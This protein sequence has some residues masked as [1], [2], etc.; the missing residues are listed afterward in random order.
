VRNERTTER[1]SVDGCVLGSGQRLLGGQATFASGFELELGDCGVEA[2]A[3]VRAQ[4]R[5]RVSP[6]RGQAVQTAR[7][8]GCVRLDTCTVESI[9]AICRRGR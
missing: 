8:G 6:L 3:L 2:L 4:R 5:T 9:S 1:C 7:A